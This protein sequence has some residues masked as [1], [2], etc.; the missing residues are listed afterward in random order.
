MIRKVGLFAAQF[1][2]VFLPLV[3]L[4]PRVYPSYQQ[5]VLTF[6]NPILSSIDRPVEFVGEADGNLAIYAIP[7]GR[8]RVRI[9]TAPYHPHVFYLS[10]VLLPALLLATPTRL[11]ERLRWLALAMPLLFVIHVLAISVGFISQ[12][13]AARNPDDV[14]YTWIWG[15]CMTSG[16]LG[17]VG[18]WSL[19]TWPYWIPAAAGGTK[20]AGTGMPGKNALCACGSGKKYK[21]CCG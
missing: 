10:L 20:I 21:H 6:A 2:I 1:I 12:S 7:P 15:V 13:H 19:L 11:K 14:L 16:Q 9:T 8:P 4:Y 17:A 18:L 3:W 5:V